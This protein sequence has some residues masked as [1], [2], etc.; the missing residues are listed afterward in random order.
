MAN[1]SVIPRGS[2]TGDDLSG[3]LFDTLRQNRGF[4]NDR[5]LADFFGMHRS[6]VSRVRH[7]GGPV[8]QGMKLAIISKTGMSL[9]DIEKLIKKPRFDP[10]VTA[11]QQPK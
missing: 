8:T 10:K 5:Q 4:T 7:G 11:Q 3:R 6:S 9:D 2:K 1:K